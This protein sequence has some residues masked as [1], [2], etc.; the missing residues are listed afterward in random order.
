MSKPKAPKYTPVSDINLKADLENATKEN[1]EAFAE[2]EAMCGTYNDA[3]Q[4]GTGIIDEVTDL[5]NSI[6]NH[7]KKFDEQIEKINAIKIEH[8][9]IEQFKTAERKALIE[10]GLLAGAFAAVGAAFAALGKNKNKGIIGAI[11]AL[12]GILFGGFFNYFK[13]RKAKK[14]AIEAINKLYEDTFSLRQNHAKVLSLL[15]QI[16]PAAINLRALLADCEKYRGLDKLSILPLS[17]DRKKLSQL[18]TNTA[19]FAKLLS[20]KV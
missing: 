20:Q 17:E 3:L 8:L 19:S 1:E 9:T 6:A 11:I 5:I 2:M 18:V 10:G 13:K 7:P 4:D 12:I 16:Q 14:Q 15:Q